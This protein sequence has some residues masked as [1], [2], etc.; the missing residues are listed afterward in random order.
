VLNRSGQ[1]WRQDAHKGLPL[2]LKFIWP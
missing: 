1:L 2:G